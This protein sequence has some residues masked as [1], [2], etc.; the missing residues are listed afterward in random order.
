MQEGSIRKPS[1][2]KSQLALIEYRLNAL[3][4]VCEGLIKVYGIDADVTPLKRGQL[5]V[6]LETIMQNHD[7]ASNGA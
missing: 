3:R 2:I 5:L 6:Q 4:T 7:G 1:T